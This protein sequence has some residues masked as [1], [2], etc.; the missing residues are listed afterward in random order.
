MAMKKGDHINC[1]RQALNDGI[2]KSL[3]ITDEGE[4][5]SPGYPASYSRNDGLCDIVLSSPQ[6]TIIQLEF[7]DFIVTDCKL[8]F[9]YSFKKS[10]CDNYDPCEY[11]LLDD[12]GYIN[13]IYGS[14]TGRVYRGFTNRLHLR[15]CFST[16]DSSARRKWKI[17]FS[18]KEKEKS[19]QSDF[20]SQ[21]IESPQYPR[22]YRIKRSGN[23]AYNYFIKQQNN[24]PILMSFDDLDFYSKANITISYRDRSQLTKNRLLY[25]GSS[26]RVFIAYSDISMRFTATPDVKSSYGDVDHIA[27]KLTFHALQEN[28]VPKSIVSER[29]KVTSSSM[30][31]V[32]Y[33]HTSTEE[34]YFDILWKIYLTS[35][36]SIEK[37]YLKIQKFVSEPKL[38]LQ[39]KK[40][41]YSGGEQLNTG[42]DVTNKYFKES[43]GF[44]VRLYGLGK[45]VVL[46]IAIAKI[47][48]LFCSTYSSYKCPG[49]AVCLDRTRK[50]D[51]Y[52][53]CGNNADEVEYMCNPNYKCKSSEY[54][55]ENRMCISSHKKCNGLK[56]CPKNED[57]RYCFNDENENRIHGENGG[58]SYSNDYELD[59]DG[60]NWIYIVCGVVVVLISLC[61]GFSRYQSR[62]S[63]LTF[64]GDAPAETTS[65]LTDRSIAAT[66]GTA[67]TYETTQIHLPMT[68]PIPASSATPAS[69]TGLPSS[70]P[71]LPSGLPPS[72]D[73]V[74]SDESHYEPKVTTT[75]KLAL[76]KTVYNTKSDIIPGISSADMPTQLKWNQLPLVQF[77]LS[78]PIIPPVDPRSFLHMQYGYCFR[79]HSSEQYQSPTKSSALRSMHVKW[80]VLQ[81]VFAQST[82]GSSSPRNQRKSVN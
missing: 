13:Q 59:S 23:L 72:Y 51:G 56:D 28:Q 76:E 40:E 44:Y 67:R 24:F 60:L 39:V 82:V 20:T 57:E 30:N 10:S 66:S 77:S 4:I 12:G 18:V 21:A 37:T 43:K 49:T 36:S 58:G 79:R 2:T 70:A 52:D 50:C 34:V 68:N 38:K 53:H 42:N 48:T 62:R 71:S 7:T 15:Y 80:N 41:C 26:D 22:T 45:S 78:H 54:Q 75:H 47:Q 74:M 17:V 81:N 25:K 9:D 63:R 64:L 27:W 16:Y 35:F 55:C 29:I 8:T 32:T 73:D 19:F 31:H 3:S 69:S 11:L 6:D 65:P 33:E 1:T 46:K 5:T 61:I 14:N